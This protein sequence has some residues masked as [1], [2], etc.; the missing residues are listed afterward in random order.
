MQVSTYIRKHLYMALFIQLPVPRSV[1]VINTAPIK[2][3][4]G[5]NDQGGYAGSQYNQDE[6]GGYAGSQYDVDDQGGYAGSQYNE[7]SEH[8]AGEPVNT[9]ADAPV[10][11]T[12]DTAA[13]NMTANATSS[14]KM[15]ETGNPILALFA[16]GAV[17]GAYA[18]YKRE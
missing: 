8:A 6:Q 7:T 12:A 13:Q 18:V 11:E 5:D 9:T 1:N 4:M 16:V 2:L 3:L 17:L 14:H 15:L 10:N